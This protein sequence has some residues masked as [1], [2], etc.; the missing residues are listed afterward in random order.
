MKILI[1]GGA[2]FIG[3]WL[4]KSLPMDA[5]VVLVDSLDE[6]VHKNKTD[7]AEELRKRAVCLKVDIR[8]RDAYAQALEDTE[9]VVHL[10][11][12]T[13]TGQSMYEI[14]KYV[15]HNNVIGEISVR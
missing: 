12:Q 9:V 7:F 10:T 3:K 1:T 13:G 15:Q 11:A 5:E 2:G 14:S 6:Q 8:V 4:V